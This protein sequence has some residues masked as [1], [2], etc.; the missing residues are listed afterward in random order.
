MSDV[1]KVWG[2]YSHESISEVWEGEMPSRDF[3]DITKEGY[4]LE[5]C[6]VMDSDTFDVGDTYAYVFT[7]RNYP[8][9]VAICS[10]CQWVNE[11]PTGTRVTISIR[12]PRGIPQLYA[13]HH[14]RLLAELF[15]IFED[16]GYGFD[17]DEMLD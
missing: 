13:T 6:C 11:G 1:F 12:V 3:L 7:H 17:D 2:D 15:K 4:H 16:D 14:E 10:M 9:S 8:D 5:H